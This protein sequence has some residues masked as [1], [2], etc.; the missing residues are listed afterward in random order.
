MPS[1]SWEH[2]FGSRTGHG[3]DEGDQSVKRLAAAVFLLTISSSSLAAQNNS[4]PTPHIKRFVAPQYP[5]A[6]RKARMQGSTTSELHIRAE[7]TV[8]SVNVTMAHAAFEGF[9][10]KAL[11]QWTFEPLSAATTLKVTV[12]FSLSACE[13]YASSEETFVT[14]DMPNAVEITACS[15]PIETHV[16]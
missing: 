7:G 14:A 12:K 6:A 10:R 5:A 9:V 1:A 4:T 16:N 15:Q 3:P 11:S 8:E 2:Q 13:P